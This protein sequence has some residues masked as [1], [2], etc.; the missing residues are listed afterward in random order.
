MTLPI[1]DVPLAAIIASG[2]TAA[3]FLVYIDRLKEQHRLAMLA[4]FEA[5]RSYESEKMRDEAQWEID[6]RDWKTVAR[7]RDQERTTKAVAPRHALQVNIRPEG[8]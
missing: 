3:G 6:N 7:N 5:G 4:E 2:L 8:K 1:I